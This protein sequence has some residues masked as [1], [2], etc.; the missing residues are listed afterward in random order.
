MR[1][2]R[3]QLDERH[4][5]QRPSLGVGD[6]VAPHDGDIVRLAN[7]ELRFDVDDVRHTANDSPPSP[8]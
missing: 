5:G 1:A 6:I 7:T 8:R 3:P 4:V 2:E